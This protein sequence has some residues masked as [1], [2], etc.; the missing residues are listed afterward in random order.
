MQNKL[1]IINFEGRITS[2]VVIS[3]LDK[4]TDTRNNR[5]IPSGGDSN[6]TRIAMG[7]RP[8][9]GDRTLGECWH[10]SGDQGILQ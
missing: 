4:F 1:H 3:C 5:N 2:E 9:G 7:T 6:S 10:Y 8:A